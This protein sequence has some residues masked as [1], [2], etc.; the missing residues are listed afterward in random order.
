MMPD[1]QSRAG[2]IGSRRRRRYILRRAHHSCSTAA[3]TTTACTATGH[4]NARRS[5]DERRGLGGKV[6]PQLDSLWLPGA[7]R[8]LCPDRRGRR[9]DG[10]LIAEDS[11]KY[12]TPISLASPQGLPYTTD[13]STF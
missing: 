1:W 2:T 5:P 11:A 6:H 8:D 13:T 7:H 9:L 4:G 10:P 12:V 3:C